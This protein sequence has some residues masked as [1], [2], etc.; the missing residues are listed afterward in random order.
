MMKRR[1]VRTWQIALVAGICLMSMSGRPVD[2]Q[3]PGALRILACN[4]DG[5]YTC[6]DS[7]GLSD[8][9]NLCCANCN[10]AQ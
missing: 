3:G 7:C 2:A 8:D 6:G 10:D 5:T 4:T 9:C 1:L